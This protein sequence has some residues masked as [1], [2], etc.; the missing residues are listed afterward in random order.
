MLK[1]KVLDPVRLVLAVDPAV[2]MERSDYKKYQE[3]W[4]L[5]HLVY[6]EG[7]QPT[8]F[9]VNQLTCR[10]KL[11]IHGMSNI[12]ERAVLAVRLGLVAVENYG[13]VKPDGGTI[14]LEQPKRQ[15]YSEYGD[16]ITE[17]WMESARFL[18]EELLAIGGCIL[19]IT[20]ARP[21]LS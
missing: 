19:I 9:V 15:P 1:R 3:T 11:F 12:V 5:K 21:P 17:E 6:H 2:D 20:E 8:V 4:D 14:L 18:V 10:Q 16:A 7:Q 13:I